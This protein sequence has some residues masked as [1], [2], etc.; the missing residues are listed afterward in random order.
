[1][2]EKPSYEPENSD[3]YIFGKIL[4]AYKTENYKDG[5][6]KVGIN[7]RIPAKRELNPQGLAADLCKTKNIS[8]RLN[9]YDDEKP[10]NMNRL[11]QDYGYYV[12]LEKQILH[13]S[14]IHSTLEKLEI[15]KKGLEEEMEK[16]YQKEY[17]KFEKMG[18]ITPEE[19]FDFAYAIHLNGGPLK[20]EKRI[21]KKKKSDH[22]IIIKKE[23]EK[24]E[25]VIDEEIEIKHKKKREKEAEKE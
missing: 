25:K 10:L 21:I 11:G 16:A 17:G 5:T 22:A 3:K 6:I 9:F 14:L 20:K 1:M 19:R 15:A 7:F 24:L 13:K 8:V 23:E 4:K 12:T 2:P 18:K